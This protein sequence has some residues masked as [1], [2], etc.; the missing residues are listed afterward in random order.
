MSK[1]G[2]GQPSQVSN[3]TVPEYAKP[4]MED[5]LGRGMAS[6]FGAKFGKDDQ[7]NTIVEEDPNAAS[8]KFEDRIFGYGDAPD[9]N[10]QREK[11]QVAGVRIAGFTPDELAARQRALNMQAPQGFQDAAD[12]QYQQVTANPISGLPQNI[13]PEMQARQTNFQ[14]GLGSARQ[15]DA[16]E[17]QKYADQYQQGVTD[18]QKQKAI[19]D[20]QKAQLVTN[21]A[22]A[23]Q[24][25]YGGA[26]QTL[27]GLEREKALG[28]NLAQIQ[29]TGSQKGLEFAAQQFERDRSADMQREA[30]QTD[31]GLKVAM[32]NLSNEQQAAVQN[33]AAKLQTQGLNAN[34]ALKIALD[35]S[36]RS[37]QAQLANQRAAAQQ[38]EM[39]SRNAQAQAQQ[40]MA[41]GQMQL[42]VAGAER[43]L[44]Q[45][46]LDEQRKMFQEKAEMPYKDIGFMSDLLRG[47]SALRGGTAMYEAPQTALQ[48]IVGTGLPAYAMYRGLSQ[49]S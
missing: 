44:Q 8:R 30:M 47:T 10:K 22:S 3:I 2:G 25:T 29:A 35:N 49:P 32:Q 34:Q 33:Q 18:I 11:L 20:Q 40:E 26:R 17:R 36:Q 46:I 6:S 27:A 28:E 16:S 13:S 43:Q 12:Y 31:V 15:F 4:Y 7:G 23:R 37:M 38:A 45:Q 9:I 21:L 14:S 39:A 42:G 41:M 5:L 19:E 1:G 48:Q 24:G